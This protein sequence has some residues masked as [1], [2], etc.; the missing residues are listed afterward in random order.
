MRLVLSVLLAKQVTRAKPKKQ[1][2]KKKKNLNTLKWDEWDR[3]WN[4]GR[5]KSHSINN[6]QKKKRESKDKRED[7]A[8]KE[9]AAATKLR[10][11]LKKKERGWNISRTSPCKQVA[12]TKE[13]KK[14]NEGAQKRRGWS[15][16]WKCRV[17]TE[18]GAVFGN[19]RAWCVPGGGSQAC[20]PNSQNRPPFSLYQF[21]YLCIIF[22]PK[23]FK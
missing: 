7:E 2:K 14:E 6:S 11:K 12:T 15:F 23:I 16:P 21:I 9:R 19:E 8:S 1:E 20:D 13:R 4:I 18:K 3:E 10:K 17:R 5:R 22:L